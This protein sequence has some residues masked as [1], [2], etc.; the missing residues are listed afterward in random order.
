VS[1][2]AV[3]QLVVA[4]PSAAAVIVVVSMFLRF[5]REERVT[6]AQ[7]NQAS[8]AVLERLRTALETLTSE[9]RQVISR[10]D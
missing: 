6:R 4:V 1:P 7:E 9:I 5:M 10:R 8:H 2:E 3:A